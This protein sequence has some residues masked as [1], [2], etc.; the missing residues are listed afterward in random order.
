MET[1]T[2]FLTLAAGTTA[3]VGWAMAVAAGGGRR[4]P[5]AA[6][7]A[8]WAPAAAPAL[9][10][11]AS[12][13][14]SPATDAALSLTAAALCLWWVPMRAAS[15]LAGYGPGAE[16]VD[17]LAARQA[18]DAAGVDAAGCG[19]AAHAGVPCTPAR[20]G[21]LLLLPAAYATRRSVAAGTPP[22]TSA[23]AAAVTA[24]AAVAG[25]IVGAEVGPRAAAAAAA[26]APAAAAA[27]SRGAALAGH[28][29]LAAGGATAVTATA[30]AVA[31]AAGLAVHP[32]FGAPSPPASLAAFWGCQW[33]RP[34]AQLLR[35]GVYEPVRDALRWAMA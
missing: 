30:T 22:L 9:A 20:V 2:G 11:A 4:L 18:D 5:P 27:A 12:R 10:T 25:L 19:H 33:N 24:A 1:L 8:A 15:A 14:F 32:P 35:H 26:A 31:A 7:L 28:A 23:A 13:S 29:A 17:A 21:V 16:C 34:A 6:R 3:A